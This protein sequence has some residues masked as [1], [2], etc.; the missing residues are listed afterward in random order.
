VATLSVT[1]DAK[2]LM[3]PRARLETM[4]ASNDNAAN[5]LVLTIA[6]TLARRLAAV[7]Q[8]IIGKPATP[9]AE[10]TETMEVSDADVIPIDDDDLDVLDKLWG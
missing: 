8:R 9:T 10:T 3:I 4:L 6:R 7:N 5:K 1:E 2:L